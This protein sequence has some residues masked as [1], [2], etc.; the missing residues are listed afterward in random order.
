MIPDNYT[1]IDS[2]SEAWFW[3]GKEVL[4]E[5]GEICVL[6]NIHEDYSTVQYKVSKIYDYFTLFYAPPITLDQLDDEDLVRYG[7]YST[8]TNRH[9]GLPVG[10]WKEAIKDIQRSEMDTLKVSIGRKWFPV[11]VKK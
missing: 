9:R 1:R 8:A 11:E 4:C 3:L 10:E 6:E 2:P 5:E 7:D